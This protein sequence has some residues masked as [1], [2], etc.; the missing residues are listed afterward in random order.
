[1]AKRKDD[2]RVERF[3]LYMKGLEIANGYTELLDAGEQRARLAR[4]NAARARRGMRVFPSDEQFLEALGRIGGPIAGV[5]V[6]LDRLLMALSGKER[7][8]EVLPER[9]TIG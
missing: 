1:M 6:G 9:F 8:G 7:I 2:H 4:D 3:E 5:S